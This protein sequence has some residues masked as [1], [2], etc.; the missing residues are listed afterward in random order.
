MPG[1]PPKDPNAKR[2]RTAAPGFTMLPAEGRPGDPP[3]WPL[4]EPATVA[5]MNVWVEAWR[6]PQAVEWERIGAERFV[7]RWVQW[8]I[9]AEEPGA[10][11]KVLAEVRQLEDRLGLTPMA[12]LRLRWQVAD[13]LEPADDDEPAKPAGRRVRAVDPGAA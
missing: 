4:R 8:V 13:P 7:A 2:R 5:E 12:M 6:R 3:P 10:N 9:R 1:P 11:A